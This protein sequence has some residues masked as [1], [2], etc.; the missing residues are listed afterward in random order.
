MEFAATAVCHE[1]F[2]VDRNK[3]LSYL[4]IKLLYW[5]TRGNV[6]AIANGDTVSRSGSLQL[7]T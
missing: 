1:C 6:Y 3:L 5:N 4:L 7:V 2:D